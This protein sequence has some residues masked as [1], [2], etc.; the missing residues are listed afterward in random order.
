LFVYFL[1]FKFKPSKLPT[2]RD[3]ISVNKAKKEGIYTKSKTTDNIAKIN[4]KMPEKKVCM[5][6][7]KSSS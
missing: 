2:K 4:L 7:F 1:S 5:A 6:I 3:P